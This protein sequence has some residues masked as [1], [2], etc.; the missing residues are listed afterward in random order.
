MDKVKPYQYR[1]HRRR[2]VYEGLVWSA[3]F[4]PGYDVV[5]WFCVRIGHHFYSD[6]VNTT[7]YTAV[8]NTQS[9]TP[10]TTVSDTPSTTPN[11]T[12]S[13][14][15][16]TTPNTTVNN[17]PSTAPKKK[18]VRAIAGGAAGGGS[19]V[20]GPLIVGFLN[21]RNLSYFFNSLVRRLLCIKIYFRNL[22][23]FYSGLYCVWMVTF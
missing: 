14:T 4:S 22:I 5:R 17:T 18:N 16:S 10:N 13:N 8:N 3:T 1:T 2:N 20:V 21:A 7:R 9:T 12:V 19:V 6:L 11:T 15:P 23:I